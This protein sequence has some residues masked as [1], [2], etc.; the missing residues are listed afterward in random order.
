MPFQAF[1]FDFDGVLVD[2][3]EVKTKAFAKL[4]NRF[5]P[6]IEKLVIAHHR[7]QGGMSRFDKIRYYYREFLQLPISDEELSILCQRFAELVVEKVVEANEILGAEVF[8]Q[9]CFGVGPCFVVSGTPEEE[10]NE[11]ISRRYAKKYFQSIQ[12]SPKNK[13][14]NLQKLLG[15]YNLTPDNC[16]FFGDAASDYLAANACGIP[17]V[18][19]VPGVDSPLLQEYPHIRWFK[20]FV[21]LIPAQL[22]L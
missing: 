17:F 4:F 11:I 10:M 6:E 21:N 3:V 15:Q 16:V 22:L 13:V 7:S 14:E 1:F 18:G 20:D 5:G 19:I 8:L 2:S 9:A 12:G